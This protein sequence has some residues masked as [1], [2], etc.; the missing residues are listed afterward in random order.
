MAAG[1]VRPPALPALAVR[2]LH[3]SG[4][5]ISHLRILS[6]GAVRERVRSWCGWAR[7]LPPGRG[8]AVHLHQP[9]RESL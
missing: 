1:A 6:A 8:G 2:V 7:V 9:G 3:L 4:F 5:R